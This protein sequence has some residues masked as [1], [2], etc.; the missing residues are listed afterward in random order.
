MEKVY[1][2]ITKFRHGISGALLVE[3]FS[4]DRNMNGA[5][6]LELFTEAVDPGTIRS[7][8]HDDNLSQSLLRFQQ[9]GTT[10]LFATN[11]LQFLIETFP[12]RSIGRGK[13]IWSTTTLKSKI[14]VPLVAD[15]VTV[16]N[17][18]QSDLNV[19]HLM[20]RTNS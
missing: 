17:K 19:F 7:L 20:R 2:Q 1:T 18:H 13:H 4:L 8:G 14:Y 10:S 6:H 9:D 11:V 16:L 3:P 12:A 15:V 5:L